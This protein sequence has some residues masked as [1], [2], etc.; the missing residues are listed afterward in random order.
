MS[1][2]LSRKKKMS[3]L[4]VIAVGDK[5]NA[6]EWIEKQVVHIEK[7]S[8]YMPFLSQVLRPK[9]ICKKNAMDVIFLDIEM[10]EQIVLILA[11]ELLDINTDVEIIFLNRVS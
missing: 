7:V 6:L 1:A 3:M 5:P 4:K 8:V 10:P 9:N 11:E 2:S